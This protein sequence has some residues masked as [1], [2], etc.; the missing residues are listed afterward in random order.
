M[1]AEPQ[2]HLTRKSRDAS[3]SVRAT[4][5]SPTIFPALTEYG[6]IEYG[7]LPVRSVFGIALCCWRVVGR[8]GAQGLAHGHVCQNTACKAVVLIIIQ[9]CNVFRSFSSKCTNLHN[10]QATM[11]RMSRLPG[12]KNS[13]IQRPSDPGGNERRSPTR[14]RK[15]PRWASARALI[16]Q[17]SRPLSRSRLRSRC[18]WRAV[19][20]SICAAASAMSRRR[21]RIWLRR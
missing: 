8:F 2:R 19:V 13:V 4:R 3:R 15:R 10:Y 9:A 7:G 6:Q 21:S 11:H 18:C 12:Q 14:E 20:A 5:G 16:G 1:F 17:S